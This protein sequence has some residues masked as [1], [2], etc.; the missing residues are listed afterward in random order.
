M[1]LDDLSEGSLDNLRAFPQVEFIEGDIKDRRA[2]L[3]AAR[4]VN[5]IFHQ[6]AIRSVPRSVEEP[7]L[8]TEVNVVGTLNVLLAAQDVGA[9]VVSASSSS[10]YGDQKQLPVQESMMLLPRSP[11]AASKMAGEVYCQAWWRGF[12]I[13]TVALRYFNA[14]GARQSPHSQYAA[15]IPLFT[16]ACLRGEQPLIHGDGEQSR[17]FTYIDDVVQA[18][19]LAA[20]ADEKAFGRAF[21]I[22]GGATPTS[23]NRV[24]E[25][26][27]E[28]TGTDPSPVHTDPRPGDVRSSHADVSLAREILG[29][30]PSVDVEEG[31]RRTVDWFKATVSPD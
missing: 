9:R 20:R 1:G 30:K 23:I 3:T 22:G 29:Y 25:M 4:G 14:F 31:L 6:A 15:V 11:Y 5:V 27:A 21:N 17:D 2:L 8:T 10:V 12:A 16:L 13:P 24:L 19:L 26:I 7:E 28:F 18:N